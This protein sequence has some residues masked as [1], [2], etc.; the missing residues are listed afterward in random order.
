[1][2]ERSVHRI[3]TFRCGWLCSGQL[4]AGV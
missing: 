1:M 3:N 2:A 4:C